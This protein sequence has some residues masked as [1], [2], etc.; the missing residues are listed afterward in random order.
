MTVSRIENGD[1][2]YKP[3]DQEASFGGVCPEIEG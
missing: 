2:C 3:E 1:P